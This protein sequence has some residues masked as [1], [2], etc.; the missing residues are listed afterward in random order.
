MDRLTCA[1]VAAGVLL[2]VTVA[3]GLA[4]FGQVRGTVTDEWGNGIES[5]LVTAQTDGSTQEATTDED[6]DFLFVGLSSGEWVFEFRADSF[7]PASMSTRVQ[8]LSANRP[9]EVVLTMS[10]SRF[11]NETEFEAEGGMPRIKFGADGSFE[12]EDT[13]G[14]GEGTYGIVEQS[15]VMI[16]RDYDGPD[17][18]YSVNAPVVVTFADALFTSLTWSDTTLVKK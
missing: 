4:Q 1:T 5:T 13:N 18:A 10:G 9:I 12:F 14:D 3:H 11:V 17:G 15:A 2:S 8:R 6:G 16:I 7:Q